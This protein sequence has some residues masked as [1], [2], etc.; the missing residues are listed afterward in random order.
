MQRNVV[1]GVIVFASAFACSRAMVGGPAPTRR[2]LIQYDSVVAVR[3]PGPHNG[4]GETTAYPFFAAE[5]G[6]ALVFRK[7]ALHPRAA[8]G[9]HRNDVDE[10]YYVL[11]GRGE[12]TLNGAEYLVEP[13][14]AILTRAGDSHGLRQLGT[15]DLVIIVSYPRIKA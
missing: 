9:Y 8:I 4:G 13:G 11:S 12:L 3:E 5:D 15:E 6:F 1:L 7:R 2:S 10:I 14:V